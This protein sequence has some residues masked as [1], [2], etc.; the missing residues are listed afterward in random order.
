MTLL[1]IILVTVA[2]DIPIF[3]LSYNPHAV[4]AVFGF[5]WV[6]MVSGFSLVL[7]S[8]LHLIF[9]NPKL[10]RALLLVIIGSGICLHT[11]ILVSEFLLRSNYITSYKIYH[12]I[13]YLDV[14]YSV[15]E[16][17]LST[18]YIYL[19]IRFVRMGTSK[20]SSHAHLRRTTHLLI[21]AEAVVVL[22]DLAVNVLLYQRLY[23]ARRM[24]LTFVC[25]F[26]LRVEFLVL[27]RLASSAHM[28]VPL[29]VPE[30]DLSGVLRNA[31]QHCTLSAHT[32][33]HP[34]CVES[35]GSELTCLALSGGWK[36]SSISG[37][38][39]ASS[40]PDFYKTT[41]E[42]RERV[43]DSMEELERRYLGRFEAD[44]IV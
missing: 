5:G 39:M 29:P 8:R 15:Q 24:V 4:A 9:P 20:G 40:L 43:R 33:I 31:A 12:F 30:E 22:T 1:G 18:A 17:V 36:R 42:K 16:V 34:E 26:Q 41:G 19:F 25:A 28:D 27:N 44:G 23:L 6:F 2:Y 21:V 13:S 10:I 37:G 38:T 3:T 7:Y 35:H 11:P 32:S 14:I